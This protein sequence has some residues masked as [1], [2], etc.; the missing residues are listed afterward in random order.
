MTECVLLWKYTNDGNREEIVKQTQ[1]DETDLK[2]KLISN[3][4]PWSIRS[5]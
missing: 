4:N 3:Q 5:F 1:E 2:P